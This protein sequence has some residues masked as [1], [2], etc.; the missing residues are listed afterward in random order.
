M[1][2]KEQREERKK[3]LRPEGLG[4]RCGEGVWRPRPGRRADGHDAPAQGAMP[5][6]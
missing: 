6:A 1:A 5:L 4:C 3:D 2:G